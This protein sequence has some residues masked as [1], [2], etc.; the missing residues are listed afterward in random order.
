LAQVEEIIPGLHKISLL[1]PMHGLSSVFVYLFRDGNDSLLVDSGWNDEASYENLKVAFSQIDFKIPDLKTIILSHLH[2]DHIG[3]A[4]RLKKEAPESKLLMH[5]RDAQDMVY[6][7]DAYKVFVERLHSFLKMHG[8]PGVDLE[9]MISVV[10]P[11]EKQFTG[12]ARP[13]TLLKGGETL[14][15]GKWKIGVIATPG[16]TQ[17]NICLYEATSNILFSGDHILPTI[18]PN[19]SLSPIYEGDPLGD[20]LRSLKNLKKLDPKKILP[21]HEYVFE[22]LGKRIEEIEKHHEERLAEVMKAL[23]E[24][25]DESSG[26]EVAEKLIWSIGSFDKLSPWQKRAAITETLAHLEYLKRNGKVLEFHE[27][28]AVNETVRYSK[29]VN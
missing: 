20:Y 16:H 26:Y 29:I 25:M 2:P 21:S 12:V 28:V 1:L 22:H 23:G 27:G 11:L 5:A 14:Q 6:T 13:D 9:Q 4:T 19:V 15:V 8:A 3:L 17:G 18:T 24:D 7:P 10:K